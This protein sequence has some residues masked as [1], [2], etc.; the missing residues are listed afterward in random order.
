MHVLLSFSGEEMVLE[1]L[2]DGYCKHFIVSQDLVHYYAYHLVGL[3]LGPCPGQDF[4]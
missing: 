3:K 1:Y 2:T 4:A